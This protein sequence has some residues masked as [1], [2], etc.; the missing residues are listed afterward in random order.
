MLDGLDLLL[1]ATE[2]GEI[3]GGGER[4][5]ESGRV[6]DG[7]GGGSVGKVTRLLDMISSWQEVGDFLLSTVPFQ[8]HDIHAFPFPEP[9]C[10]TSG[11]FDPVISLSLALLLGFRCSCYDARSRLYLHFMLSLFDPQSLTSYH[12]TLQPILR[13]FP[14]PTA[15]YP[16][17]L[18]HPQS[19]SH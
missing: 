11:P 6:Q 8:I 17:A 16:P 10:Q 12:F 2:P 3:V 18:A 15:S 9:R 4:A 5:G 13:D 1:A 7:T 19:T 14:L